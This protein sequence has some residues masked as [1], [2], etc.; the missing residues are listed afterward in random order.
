MTDV[1]AATATEVF[2]NERRVLSKG[3]I[4]KTACLV[5]GAVKASGGSGSEIPTP[6]RRNQC[7]K[8]ELL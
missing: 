6:S 5:E 7:I 3:I 8:N 1:V 4:V 2:K